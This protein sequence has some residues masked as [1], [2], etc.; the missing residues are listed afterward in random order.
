VEAA[1]RGLLSTLLHRV[2]LQQDYADDAS[3][4]SPRGAAA[5][6]AG[7]GPAAAAAAGTPHAPIDLCGGGRPLQRLSPVYLSVCADPASC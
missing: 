2:R 7:A 6:S 3:A 5:S 4:A 1:W